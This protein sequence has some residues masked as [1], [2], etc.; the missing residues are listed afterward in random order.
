MSLLLSPLYYHVILVGGCFVLTAV[1]WPWNGSLIWKLTKANVQPRSIIWP[2]GKQGCQV[3]ARRTYVRGYAQAMRPR[4]NAANQVDHVKRHAWVSHFYVFICPIS[5]GMGLR[6]SRHG[7]SS[8]KKKK[9]K[10]RRNDFFYDQY[11]IDQQKHM[12]KQ[13]NEPTRNNICIIDSL[14]KLL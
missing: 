7:R 4:A 6:S 9:K 2:M 12:N 13:T 10:N 3:V 14:T 1:N 8:A 11:A 5:I